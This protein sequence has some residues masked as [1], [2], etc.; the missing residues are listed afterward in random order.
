M[1][2]LEVEQFM[3]VNFDDRAQLREIRMRL[4]A[5]FRCSSAVLYRPAFF[6]WTIAASILCG[7]ISP[8]YAQ[9][10]PSVTITAPSSPLLNAPV[11]ISF[12]M[13]N[14]SPTPGDTGFYPV[15]ELVVPKGL[16]ANC[17]VS[18][19][20]PSGATASCTEFGPAGMGG[21]SYTNPITG[22]S[23]SIAE[24]ASL[25]VIKVPVGTLSVGQPAIDF[26]LAATQTTDAAVGT[27]MIVFG[28]GIF[29]TGDAPNGSFVPCSTGNPPYNQTFA[30]LRLW[31][32]A[33]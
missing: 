24:G 11:P 22:E 8:A 19:T 1:L 17:P 2:E 32:Q 29:A 6:L 7:G 13:V 16:D 18:V 31:L 28:R 21:A 14:A 20:N 26:S 15:I 30:S 27:P 4:S 23:L 33:T 5:L 3:L 10:E 25:F 9:P 12:S